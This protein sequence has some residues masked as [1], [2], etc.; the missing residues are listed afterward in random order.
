[1][2]FPSL[3]AKKTGDFVFYR[4]NNRGVVGSN[5]FFQSA[6]AKEMP[7]LEELAHAT[8]ETLVDVLGFP[9]QDGPGTG[10]AGSAGRMM[11][12]WKVCPFLWLQ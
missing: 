9:E 5:G 8:E 6:E 7:K 2:G 10:T 4:F 11:G 12:R 3:S 1:M